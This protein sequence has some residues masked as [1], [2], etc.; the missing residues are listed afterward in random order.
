MKLFSQ[1]ISVIIIMTSLFAISGCKEPNN[2]KIDEDTFNVYKSDPN[3]STESGTP[4]MSAPATDPNLEIWINEYDKKE[5]Q[6]EAQKKAARQARSALLASQQSQKS[7]GATLAAQEDIDKAAARVKELKGSIKKAP[8]G[9]IIFVKMEAAGDDANSASA[10]TLDD[11]KLI[12]RLYDLESIF[13]AG[14]TFNDEYIA[15]LKELKK[16]TSVTLNNTN[17]QD[18]S[19]EVLATLPDLTTLDLRRN[20]KLNNNSLT[21]LQKM[22]KIEKLY[23]HYNTFTNSGIA[24]LRKIPTLKVVDTRGCADISNNSAKYLAALPELEEVYFRNTMSNEAV[25]NLTAAPKLKFVEF[26]DCNDINEGS[27]ESFKKCSSLTGLRMFRCKSFGDAAIAGIVSIP[28]ERLELRDL[29]VSNDG[30]APLKELQKIKKLEL[31]ELA[32]VNSDGLNNVLSSIKN[33]ET[34]TLFS[35]PLNDQGMEMIV[36]NNPDLKELTVRTVALTDVGLNF[37]LMLNKLEVLDL[38]ENENFSPDAILKLA[39]IKT[40]KRLYLK[41]TGIVARG[42]EEKLAELKK[43]LPK[44]D[45]KE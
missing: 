28:F 23:I 8:N 13:F 20:L 16:L 26:Q 11:M 29:N 18:A 31:S 34:L 21:I 27:V 19:L 7:V 40:L 10:I 43:A 1:R 44:C 22:P 37:I 42:N 36:Q 30:I 25:E 6:K 15:Q 32:S 12:G 3:A 45:I 24:K 39:Q 33:L 41:S 35:I 2:T 38:R 9:A 14:G 17:I 4:A 5:A